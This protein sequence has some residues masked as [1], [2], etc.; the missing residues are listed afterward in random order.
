[1]RREDRARGWLVCSLLAWFILPIS[2]QA[3]PAAGQAGA[4]LKLGLD[5]RAQGLGNAYTAVCTGSAAA[6]WNPAGLARVLRQEAMFTY[7]AFPGSG[8]YS[9]FAYAL[10]LNTFMFPPDQMAGSTGARSP[11]TLAIFLIR[12]A[13]SYNIEA[14][15]IDSL[16]PDYLFSDI[17]GSYSLAFGLPVWREFSA[18]LAVKGLTHELGRENATGWG[19]DAGLM[20]EG[21][22][23]LTVALA[24]RDAYANLSWTTGHSEVF[25]TTM[26][27]GAAYHWAVIDQHYLLFSVDGEYAF[28]QRAPRPRGG[29]EYG[30][31]QMVFLRAGYDDGQLAFG[32]G[33]RLPDI[34]WGRAGLQLDYAALEDRIMDWDHWVTLKLQ[35]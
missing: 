27:V 20:W 5:A 18:G 34:G 11:G 32:G 2:A 31:Y 22:E 15:Q 8:D 4:F 26:K 23:G 16:N 9:Q 10:P 17:E 28:T 33:I 30:F 25:P 1:M 13:A 3:D 19:L 21:V 12:L 29:M 24:V 14:R 35:L 7:T 6:Y